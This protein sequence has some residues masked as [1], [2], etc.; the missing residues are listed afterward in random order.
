MNHYRPCVKIGMDD[1]VGEDRDKDFTISRTVNYVNIVRAGFQNF[2]D[3]AQQ[4]PGIGFHMQPDELKQVKFVLFEWYGVFE[5]DHD[6]QLAQLIGGLTV[7]DAFQLEQ[8]VVL[9]HSQ[10]LN[11]ETADSIGIGIIPDINSVE[12]GDAF[13]VVGEDSDAQFSTNAVRAQNFSE[14]QILGVGLL[15]RH[16]G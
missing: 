16:R 12:V 3:L 7:I 10:S 11:G 1:G 5:I 2:A 15:G 9:V 14:Q 13:G 6:E 4:L 8:Q